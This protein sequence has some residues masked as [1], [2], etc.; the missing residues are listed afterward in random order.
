MWSHR[1]TPLWALVCVAACTAS[2][3]DP[4]DPP[5]RGD[6][7]AAAVQ[8]GGTFITEALERDGRPSD[9]AIMSSMSD[10]VFVGIVATYGQEVAI[11]RPVLSRDR[12]TLNTS[13]RIQVV[14]TLKGALPNEISLE[15]PGG[16]LEFPDGAVVEVRTP[17]FRIEAGRHYVFFARATLDDG[18]LAPLPVYRL[19]SGVRGVVDISGRRVTSMARRPPPF[20]GEDVDAFMARLRLTLRGRR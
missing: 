12:R 13:L 2:P 7:H 16:R 8:N 5:G 18:P 6:L 4:L 15:V 11:A 17:G 1:T 19:M 20:I 3:E 9:I 10:A 14:E